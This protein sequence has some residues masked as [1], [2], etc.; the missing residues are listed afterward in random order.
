MF[1]LYT[2]NS[3]STA[4]KEDTHT[5]QAN[6]DSLGIFSALFAFFYLLSTHTHPFHHHVIFQTAHLPPDSHSWIP[7]H[8]LW[9]RCLWIRPGDECPDKTS[10]VSKGKNTHTHYKHKRES[11]PKKKKN[12]RKRWSTGVPLTAPKPLPS[13]P[14][15]HLPLSFVSKDQIK[16]P[17]EKRRRRGGEG[18]AVRSGGAKGMNSC[19][20]KARR[21]GR[22]GEEEEQ[23][24]V[25]LKRRTKKP[26]S[27][28]KPKAT[29]TATSY[30]WVT[31]P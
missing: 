23:E 13:I 12:K 3:I 24:E 28:P 25:R 4:C 15:S 22:G 21:R 16:G 20:G 26:K 31:E 29:T 10:A 17:K 11:K 27:N 14:P 8:R 30:V 1:E 9:Q 7:K 6:V 5:P 18:E 19:R 2:L